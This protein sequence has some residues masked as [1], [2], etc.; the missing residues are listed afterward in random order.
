MDVECE[1]E[2]SRATRREESCIIIRKI[3]LKEVDDRKL[4]G[5][6][7]EGKWDQRPDHKAHHPPPLLGDVPANITGGPLEGTLLSSSQNHGPL[8]FQFR[9]LLK[10]QVSHGQRKKNPPFLQVVE[11]LTEGAIP[12]PLPNSYFIN[13]QS[14]LTH[15]NSHHGDFPMHCAL[16]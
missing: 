10:S 15:N 2:E 9:P 14:L 3:F 16:C 5:R 13:K 7:F 11:K 4:H 12:L 8:L 1:G 6:H